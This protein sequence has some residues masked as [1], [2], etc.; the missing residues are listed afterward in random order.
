METGDTAVKTRA[1]IF[2]RAHDPLRIEE[3]DVRSPDPDEVLVEFK[4]TGL[5]HTDLSV[6]DGVL[7]WAAPLVLGHEG[8]GVVVEAGSAVDHIAVGDH[9]IGHSIP[10]CGHCPNCAS[11]RTNI[12]EEL[13]NG[14]VFQRSGFSRDGAPVGAYMGLGT[15]ANHAI[16]HKDQIARINPEAPLDKACTIGCALLTGVG[17]VLNSAEVEAGST[18]LVMGLGAIGLS[19]VQGARLAG[20]ARI[21]AVDTNDSKEEAARLVGATEFINPKKL[22][23][24]LAEHVVGITDRGADYVFECVGTIAA[25]ETALASTRPGLG[26]CCL[27]GIAPADEVLKVVPQDLV[28]GRRLLSNAVGNTKVRRDVPKIVDWFLEGKIMLDPLISH[29]LPFDR[30]NDGLR[31]MRE[32]QVIRPVFLHG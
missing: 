13:L 16:L 4:A 23:S 11:E 8:A 21:I 25:M 29:I 9:F 20:A 27:V 22:V 24:G 28:M 7:P 1:A 12:C 5:C 3:I 10:Q 6:V 15:F 32:G 2:E 17:S 30:I 26:V 19:A 18:V 14:N 31:M